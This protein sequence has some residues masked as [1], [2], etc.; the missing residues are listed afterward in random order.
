[1]VPI[2]DV[3]RC[4][5]A[6]LVL[7]LVA[8]ARDVNVLIVMSLH[9]AFEVVLDQKRLDLVTIVVVIFDVN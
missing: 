7:V 1:M 4:A 2:D 6:S 8:F 9:Y 5:V 3:G